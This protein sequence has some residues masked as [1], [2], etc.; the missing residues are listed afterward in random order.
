ME[1]NAIATVERA[2]H[3]ISTYLDQIA[4]RL[5]ITQGE[6]HVL[7]HLARYG[8]TAIST[9]HREFGHKRSTLTN[10]IDRLEG[11]KLVRR[12][13]NADDRRSFVVSLTASG[14]RTAEHVTEARDQLERDLDALVAARDL[15][16]VAAVTGALQ[17]LVEQQYSAAKA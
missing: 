1:S 11:R 5:K 15:A 2:A 7:A 10:I 17:Q 14:E 4:T 12:R 13:L 8:P 6:A 9:L 3:L 16:G